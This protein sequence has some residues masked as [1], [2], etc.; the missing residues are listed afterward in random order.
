MVLYYCT[1]HSR[2]I[3]FF[4][5]CFCFINTGTLNDTLLNIYTVG[6]PCSHTFGDF[7]VYSVCKTDCQSQCYKWSI[8]Q[9]ISHQWWSISKNGQ[10][11]GD[12]HDL[13]VLG[14]M[15]SCHLANYFS[16][17]TYNL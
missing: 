12:S 4:V 5:F 13:E 16:D 9:I 11:G 7:S 17:S 6:P 10:S 3:V 2:A 1:R 8:T 15:V 14:V